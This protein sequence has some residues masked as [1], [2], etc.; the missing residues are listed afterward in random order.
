M[1]KFPFGNETQY[2]ISTSKLYLGGDF[3]KEPKITFEVCSQATTDVLAT[4]SNV[5]D[6]YTFIR[7]N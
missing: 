5:K 3:T 1:T 4:F 7:E 6:A 2:Y